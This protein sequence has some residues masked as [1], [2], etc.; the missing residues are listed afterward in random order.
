M[1]FL[2]EGYWFSFEVIGR[3]FLEEVILELCFKSCIDIYLDIF[4]IFVR[5]ME[6]YVY[7]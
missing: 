2:K 6:E 1:G 3:G 7:R 4:L 5:L